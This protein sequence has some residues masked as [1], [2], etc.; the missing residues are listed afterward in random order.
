MCGPTREREASAPS[1][2]KRGLRRKQTLVRTEPTCAHERV[3]GPLDTENAFH[4]ALLIRVK[5]KSG[6]HR[7]MCSRGESQMKN[8]LVHD[9]RL[10]GIMDWVH[11]G[12]STLIAGALRSVCGRHNM[13]FCC[14]TTVLGFRTNPRTCSVS[15]TVS[16]R[17]SCSRPNHQAKRAPDFYAQRVSSSAPISRPAVCPDTCPRAQVQQV[18]QG[19]CSLCRKRTSHARSVNARQKLPR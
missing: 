11:A 17:T 16:S 18:Q 6:G 5:K 7:V 4:D 19:P 13:P 15:K 9:G 14:F 1:L 8:V 2:R 3:P 10:S 12:C